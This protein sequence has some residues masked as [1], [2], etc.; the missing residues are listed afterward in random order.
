[1]EAKMNL[2]IHTD[3]YTGNFEREFCAFTTGQIGM[4][5]VGDDI[6]EQYSKDIVH[7][8]WW[9]DNINQVCDNEYGCYRPVKIT[10]TPGWFNHGYG[11]HY[12]D[13]KEN[14][15]IALKEMNEY[16]VK[17]GYEIRNTLVKFPAYLSMKIELNSDIPD[18]VLE[19]FKV[20]AHYYSKHIHELHLYASEFNI[21]S[22][23]K[24]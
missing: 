16:C 11:K 8:K 12:L 13:T 2:I 9:E 21:T 24:V 14:E 6:V 3:T 10:P 5:G 17:N 4:C 1:M 18:D 20:R 15:I 23:G 7:N 22:I 19:E